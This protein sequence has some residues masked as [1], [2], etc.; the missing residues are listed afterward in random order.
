MGRYKAINIP[1]DI[2]CQHLQPQWYSYPRLLT[3]SD[4]WELTV[5]HLEDRVRNLQVKEKCVG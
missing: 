5:K 4:K 1:E 3:N 2:K